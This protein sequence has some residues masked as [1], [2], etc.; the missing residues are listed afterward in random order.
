[1]RKSIFTIVI[2]VLSLVAA[3]PAFAVNGNQVIGVGAYQEG[4]AGA[5]T[6]APFDTTT[7]ITNPAGITKI[8]GRTDFNFALFAPRRKV[9]YTATGGGETYGGSDLYLLPSIG[10]SAPVGD[11]D[12]LYVGFA[13]AVVAGMGADFGPVSAGPLFGPGMGNL[14]SRQFSQ[15]QFWKMAPTI[16]KKVNDKLSVALSLNVDYQQVQLQSTYSSAAAGTAGVNAPTAEGA[17]GY[18]FTVGALYDVS[19]MITIG[20]SY[21]SNQSMGDMKYR[22]NSGAVALLDPTGSG[23]LSTGG[24]YKMG[25]DFPQQFAVGVA[26]KPISSLTLT[27]D[28]KWIN[29]SAAYDNVDIKGDFAVLS[30]GLPTGATRD[31]ATLNFGWEDVTVIAVGAQY[32]FGDIGWLRIGYNRGNSAVPDERAFTNAALPATAE[33]HYTVGG[34]VNIG[35]HWQGHLSYVNSPPNEITDPATKTKIS[36]GGSST[37]FGFSYRF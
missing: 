34:T 8:G 6:A 28:Y 4:M 29:L 27:A 16:A 17:M 13:I 32:Q 25:L 33:D 22:L 20:V 14:T 31:K 12:S 21:I 2:A 5:V 26:V 9:D 24:T 35:K 11:D 37:Q 15:M 3:N 1:M 23:L 36:L 19:K 18:G 10:I 7:M 30:G